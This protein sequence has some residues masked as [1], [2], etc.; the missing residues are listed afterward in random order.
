MTLFPLLAAVSFS[1]NIPGGTPATGTVHLSAAAP[2][3]G[4]VV[5]LSSANTAL[6]SVPASVTVPAGQTSATFTANTAQVTQTTFIVISASSG[7]TT[8]S[9][10]LFL[11][12]SRGVASV[13]L[14][15]SSV[16]GPA[17]ST[18][19]VTLRSASTGNAVVD[20]V[21]SNSVFATVPFSVIVPP[22]QASATFTVNA[23]Q[24]TTTTTVVISATYEN[25]TQ[26]A[27]LTINPSGSSTPAAPTLVSPGNG[28]TGVAQPVTLD[29][30]NVT[31]AASYEVQVD[32]SS[33]I[34]APFT[35]NPTV[36][37]SQATLTRSTGAATVVARARAQCGGRVRAVLLDP[38][39]H[40]AE[41][42]GAGIA[43]R[44]SR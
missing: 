12:V 37:T 22:G 24:V 29:W 36:T 14:N 1:G 26:S 16:V 4:L 42:A 33:T 11:V 23:A 10:N 31:N 44:P 3:G 41:H 43:C 5:T 38:A 18:G 30:N 6:A 9:T 28:A 32:T 35:A 34:A 2:G 39:L 13:T 7:G 25:V 8:V 17:S 40:A 27:T 19:T 21:S 20:L 15:P